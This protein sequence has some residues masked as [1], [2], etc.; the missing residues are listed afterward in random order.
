M[1]KRSVMSDR[2]GTST[3]SRGHMSFFT[4]TRS[5]A[6]LPGGLAR[7]GWPLRRR[8]LSLNDGWLIRAGHSPGTNHR[9]LPD[10]TS[11]ATSYRSKQTIRRR[12]DRSYDYRVPT[13]VFVHRPVYNRSTE[14]DIEVL[15]SSSC[16]EKTEKTPSMQSCYSHQ[17]DS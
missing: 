9:L 7:R 2:L 3:D 17:S 14:I 16:G 15:I 11:R 4:R 12:A 1:W 13:I 10:L 5:S 6:D 8:G